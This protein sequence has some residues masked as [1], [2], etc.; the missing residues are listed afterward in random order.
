MEAKDWIK[1]EDRLPE[2]K[3]RTDIGK[4]YSD[5]VLAKV[6]RGNTCYSLT[7]AIYDY[8]DDTWYN[9]FDEEIQVTHWMSIVL[10]KAD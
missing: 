2:A 10:P 5:G 6:W 7:D 9:G 8:D 1:V 4:G 3:Y